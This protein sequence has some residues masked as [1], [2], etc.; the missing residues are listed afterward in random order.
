MDTELNDDMTPCYYRGQ[1]V[2]RYD[3]TSDKM[4]SIAELFGVDLTLIDHY[5]YWQVKTSDELD[6]I[7]SEYNY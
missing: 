6:L 5:S 7:L 2:G 4:E 3:E 1:M